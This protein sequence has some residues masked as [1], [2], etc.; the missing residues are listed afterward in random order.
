MKRILFLP[1]YLG[2]GY[3]H[4]SRCLVF[5]DELK[6]R[7]WATAFALGGFHASRLVEEGRRVFNLRRPYSPKPDSGEGPAFT[8]FTDFNYQLV[9]DGLV[10]GRAVQSCLAEQL[11]AVRRF[12]PDVLVS[13]SWSLAGI[14]AALEGLPLVQIVRTATHPAAPKLMWWQDPPQGLITPDPRPVFNTILE[15]MGLPEIEKGED[16]LQGDL[17]LVPS[18]PDLD[19]LPE[20]GNTYYVGP[21]TRIADRKEELPEW[22]GRFTSQKPLVYVTLGGGAGPVGGPRFYKM[23]FEALGNEEI[24]VVA[25]TGRRISPDD[26]PQPP[27]NFRLE[28]WVPGGAMIERADLVVYPGGYGSTME[29]VRAGTPGLVIPFHTE[30]ES[31]GRRLEQQ[32]AG[33][34]LLPAAGS[35]KRQEK[36]WYGGSFS[37]L[38]FPESSLSPSDLRLSVFEIL[39]DSAFRQRAVRL[40][41]AASAYPGAPAAADLLEGLVVSYPQ[42]QEKVWDRLNWKQKISLSLPS[43]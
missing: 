5:G 8:V 20:M 43:F 13:D 27:R 4:I 16:L 11:K 38:V 21:L 9:R 2:G 33:K 24:Q 40:R 35:G 30:Q 17:Y 3:G 6:K 42:V 31:N 37:Y 41:E 23:L 10:S 32:G 1:S 19:P 39:E 18:V 15:G 12:Q 25:S 29:I 34:V 7:G 28:A 36:P 14:L 26:L 22:M